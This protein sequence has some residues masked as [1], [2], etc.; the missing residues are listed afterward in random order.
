MRG[1]TTGLSWISQVER[2]FCLLTDRRIRRGVHT[3]VHTS[4]QA[5]T[6][7][8]RD[9]IDTSHLEREPQTDNLGED[10]R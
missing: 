6:N 2:W 1:R 7:D 4:V 8:V 3:S 10:R 5:L 9:W